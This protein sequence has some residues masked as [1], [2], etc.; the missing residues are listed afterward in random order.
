MPIRQWKWMQCVNLHFTNV[1]VIKGTNCKFSLLTNVVSCQQRGVNLAFMTI[2]TFM[3]S[4]IAVIPADNSWEKNYN[5]TK[6]R[7][8]DQSLNVLDLTCFFWILKQPCPSLK[9]P[10]VIQQCAGNNRQ[11]SNSG[12]TFATVKKKK[13][14]KQKNALLKLLVIFVECIYFHS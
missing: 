6:K 4:Y 12:E 9:Q 14:V 2:N 11:A 3:L 10:Q 1:K 7:Q 13:G 8:V 5:K